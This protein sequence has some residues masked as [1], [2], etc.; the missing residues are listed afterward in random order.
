VIIRNF[1]SMSLGVGVSRIGNGTANPN[2]TTTTVPA[3]TDL[4]AYSTQFAASGMQGGI[5]SHY[6]PAGS[7]PGGLTFTVGGL[8]SGTVDDRSSSVTF[9]VQYTDPQGRL[10]QQVIVMTVNDP[11]A[12]NED[13]M[14]EGT[15]GE[16][17]SQQMVAT[18]GTAPIEWDISAGALPDGLTISSGGLISGTPTVVNN[19]AFTMRATD[20][21]GSVDTYATSITIA[22]AGG[23]W[24]DWTEDYYAVDPGNIASLYQD[25]ALTTPVTTDGNPVVAVKAFR[26][27]QSTQFDL[28]SNAA[29]IGWNYGD[30]AST[31]NINSL[32]VLWFDGTQ[33]TSNLLVGAKTLAQYATSSLA[34]GMHMVFKTIAGITDNKA[35]TGPVSTGGGGGPGCRYD[36]DASGVI[37]ISGNMSGFQSY[38][39]AWTDTD[40]HVLSMRCT[41]ETGDLL[42][43]KDGTLLNTFDIDALD[44]TALVGVLGAA[45]IAVGVWLWYD[46]TDANFTSHI[47]AI[48][49]YFG[50]A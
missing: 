43:Y 29:D 30:E 10:D 14:N 26:K 19:F 42:V 15:D 46:G 7:L 17:Y 28:V 12:I 31:H 16:A 47:T 9:T 39:V 20:V 32:P 34:F 1:L 23:P 45:N 25:Q 11:V 49:T 33:G 38:D 24:L 48:K 21:N 40:A 41:G 36:T 2:I 8:L 50:I 35:V 27:D 13:G 4:A 3:G 18:G 5:W 22:A 6:V 44:E 37:R